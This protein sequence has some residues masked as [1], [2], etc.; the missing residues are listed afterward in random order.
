MATMSDKAVPVC[1]KAVSSK[2]L[3]TKRVDAVAPP[4]RLLI[5]ANEIV[6]YIQKAIVALACVGRVPVNYHTRA[7]AWPTKKQP[8]C[9]KVVR[10]TRCAPRD[11][12]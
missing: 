11:P 1:S 7:D 8:I 5:C 2:T 10:Y 6:A 9:A 12:T 3:K 4:L